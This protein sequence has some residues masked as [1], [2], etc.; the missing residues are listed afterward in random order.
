MFSNT[1]PK[2]ASGDEYRTSLNLNGRLRRA[3]KRHNPHDFVFVKQ[4]ISDRGEALKGDVFERGGF[5]A[6]RTSDLTAG[7]IAVSVQDAVPAVR[8]LTREQQSCSLAIEGGS[9]F[10]ELFNGG[11]CF[12]DQRADRVR[13]AQPVA[14]NQGVLLVQFYFIVVVERHGNAAL[15]VFG[16]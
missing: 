5:A 7:G 2:A 15:G 11:G 14:G 8:T 4:Q 3:V 16:R 9:P 10:D 1:R 13:I 6:Q 12:F